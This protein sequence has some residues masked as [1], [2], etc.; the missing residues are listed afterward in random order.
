M[1]TSGAPRWPVRNVPTALGERYR[2]VGWWREETLGEAVDRSL[3]AA[4]DTGLHIW[5]RE[6]PWHGTYADVH[7]EARRLVTASARR[8]GRTRERGRVPAAELARSRRRLLRPRDGWLRAGSHRAHLR[9]EGGAL[10]PRPER[11]GRVPFGRPVRPCRLPRRR[12]RRTRGQP[13]RPRAARRGRRSDRRSP[14]RR[15]TGRMERGRRGRTGGG[16]HHGGSGRSLRP[17]VHLGHDRRAERRDPLPPD[18]ARRGHT[19]R[20]DDRGGAP[21]PD[22]VPGDPCDRHARRGARTDGAGRAD[23]SRGPLGPGARARDHAGGRDR[24]GDGRGRVPRQPARPSRVHRRARGEDP[25]SGTRRCAGAVR[26]RGTGGGARD[27]GD[28][29]VRIDRAP[30]GHERQLRRSRGEASRHRRPAAAGR[31]DAAGRRRRRAGAGRHAG[32][33]LVARSRS[34]ARLHRSRADRAARSPPTAG[35]APGTWAFSTPTATSRSP[36]G[37]TT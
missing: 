35:T 8:G 1:A 10:H 17:R 3:R 36:T 27:R 2:E 4:P 22:G 26:A 33:D 19:H 20:R 32:R 9:A 7:L 15:H 11:R 31:R 23:P 28:P 21:E 16:V 13:R 5:S 14:G 18:A 6:R 12:R 30:V 24:R 29:C 25:A 34:R 37:C